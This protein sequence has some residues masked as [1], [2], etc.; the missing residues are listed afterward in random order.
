MFHEKKLKA[1]LVHH[2]YVVL[3]DELRALASLARYQW[4]I[5][6]AAL[7]FLLAPLYLYD[8]IPPKRIVIASGTPN[9][10]AE[11][12][13]KRYQAF[14]KTAGV[15]AELRT[16]A[17]AVD[18]LEQ[19]VNRKVDVAISQGGIPFDPASGV[20]SL[21]SVEYEPLW[22]F[23]KGEEGALN[24]LFDY[25]QGKRVAI[26][27]RGS[28]TRLVVDSMLAFVP[29]EMK[30]RYDL[31]EIP[32]GEAI[33]A[34]IDG[35]IDGTF[36]VGGYDA[37]SVQRLLNIDG[38]QAASFS[39]ARALSKKI[40]H[41]EVVQVPRGTITMSP[42]KPNQDLQ[43][44][45]T[46]TMIMAHSSL[47]PALQHL[48]MKG[49]FDLY[50][51]GN[52]FF[53]RA[54]GFPGFVDK[55]TPRSEYAEHYLEKGPSALEG[56]V[57][58]WISSFFNRTWLI[59]ISALAL[60]YPIFKLLPALRKMLFLTILDEKYEHMYEIYLKLV[61][62]REMDVKRDALKEFAEL[63]EEMR[64]MWVPASCYESL[65]VF[66]NSLELLRAR[67]S[68]HFKFVDGDL[69]E[70]PDP[71]GRLTREIFNKTA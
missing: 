27:L 50:R 42:P 20:V 9:S 34:L 49:S 52:R 14:L 7:L 63:E 62:A 55:S 10:T 28:G 26:S 4:F 21:C 18:S 3:K 15:E 35:S 69:I 1:R 39:T 17:G 60:L 67:I 6:L 45:A 47:H 13:A 61:R 43:M 25:L 30:A 48:L 11:A 8:L 70:I 41:L 36:L 33:N 40:P 2:A 12:T 53:E 71:L 16:T 5:I 46:T 56:Y 19:L 51:N 54:G 22:F 23:Y 57:P 32:T 29:Q 31:K 66:L 58:F 38:V 59:L 44:I 37:G 65:G 24:D 64:A 68:A